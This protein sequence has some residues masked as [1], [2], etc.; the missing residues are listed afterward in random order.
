MIIIYY[1]NI[2]EEEPG[3]SHGESIKVLP[4]TSLEAGMGSLVVCRAQSPV[5]VKALSPC[6][7]GQELGVRGGAA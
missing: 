5:K 1:Y 6:D 3:K 4:L 2:R 7:Q